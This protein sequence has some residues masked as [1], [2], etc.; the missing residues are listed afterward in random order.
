MKL[1]GIAGGSG[2]GKTTIANSVKRTSPEETTIIP[3]DSYYN[4]NSLLTPKERI[5]LNFDHPSAFD[6]NLIYEHLI[7]L[8]KGHTIEKP[9]YSY[10]ERTRQKETEKIIPNKTL[11]IEG[12]L[13]YHDNR[14]TD[15]LDYRFFI[16]LDEKSRLENII[17]RDVKERGRNKDEI[18]ERFYSEVNPMHNTYVE[19]QKLKSHLVLYNTDINKTIN[20]VVNQIKS[21]NICWKIST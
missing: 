6:F 16:D 1:I 4:D 14:I 19:K 13:L 5:K 10:I 3:L 15:L 11:L 21:K 8:K 7:L 17:K 20:I 9:T 18:T 2:T 12:I